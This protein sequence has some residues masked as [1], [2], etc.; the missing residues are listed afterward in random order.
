M[1][2]GE[3]VLPPETLSALKGCS[4]NEVFTFA[5]DI[6]D[7]THRAIF[8]NRLRRLQDELLDSLLGSRWK[9]GNTDGGIVCP[10]CNGRSH[11]RKGFRIR[12]VITSKGIFLFSTAQ[13]Q[14][15]S[16]GR[17][18][19]PLAGLL[20]LEPR[21]RVLRELEEKAVSLAL[22]LPYAPSAEVLRELTGGGISHEG[23]RKAVARVASKETLE[24]PCDA[25]HVMVDS[26]K[27]KAGGKSR[28]EDV[29]V[30]LVVERGPVVNGRPTLTKKLLSLSV[31]DSAPLKEAL[32]KARPVNLVHDGELDL[33]GCA[34]NV[35]RCLWHM[36]HQIK[37]YLWQDEV[38][39]EQ[40]CAISKSLRSILFDKGLAG[41]VAVAAYDKLVVDLK[42]AGLCKSAK[43]LSNA[44]DEVFTYKN[45]DSLTFATTSPIE[46]EMREIN[47][48][49]D[50]GARWSVKG[51]ENVLKLK[52]KRRFNQLSKNT[53]PG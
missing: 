26:T 52:M 21:R 14:C 43:H 51:I 34:Q 30:G 38:P 53:H 9:S 15:R 22:R 1:L 47:R 24:P 46:R 28:G 2:P 50:V 3:G 37:Y 16:C 13:V 11:V 36:G 12:E 19:R 45:A 6:A 17:V 5:G 35:Q 32:L 40:R 10:K 44:R 29:Q 48:R 7:K 49:A 18:H 39:H 31:G 20:G 23:I 4:V 42:A 25:V 27:V 8:G 41:N 33:S